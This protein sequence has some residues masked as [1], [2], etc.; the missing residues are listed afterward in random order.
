MRVVH[1]MWI[2]D[3]TKPGDEVVVTFEHDCLFIHNMLLLT[4]LDD[5]SLLE[6]LHRVSMQCVRSHSHLTIKPYQYQRRY[7]SLPGIGSYVGST[8]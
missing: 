4:R 6:F 3:A 2:N 5:M 8:V 7:P 1:S